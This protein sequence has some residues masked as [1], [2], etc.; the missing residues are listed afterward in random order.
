[1]CCSGTA[2]AISRRMTSAVAPFA[3]SVRYRRDCRSCAPRTGIRVFLRYAI[4]RL[5]NS[6]REDDPSLTTQLRIAAGSRLE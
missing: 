1:M 5:R 6:F 3:N 2:Y 4:A